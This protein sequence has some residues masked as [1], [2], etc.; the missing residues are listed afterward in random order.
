MSFKHRNMRRKW[1]LK[2]GFGTE[3]RITFSLQTA[4]KIVS[5]TP[6]KKP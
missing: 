5:R 4:S 1:P 3:N 2:I 6:I